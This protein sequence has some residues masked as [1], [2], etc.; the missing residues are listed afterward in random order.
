MS[1]LVCGMIREQNTG[2][3]RERLGERQEFQVRLHSGVHESDTA[4]CKRRSVSGS[5]SRF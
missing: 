4:Q 5:F 1:S 3:E 2:D